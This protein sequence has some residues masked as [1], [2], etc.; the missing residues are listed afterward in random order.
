MKR[1]LILVEGQTEETFVREVL[2]PCVR[3]RGLFL[4]V[5]I[6]TTKRNPA[7]RDCKGGY[8]P[9]GRM[10]REI[11]LLLSDSNA[12]AVTTMIDYYSLPEDF[13]GRAELQG[14]TCYERVDHL[15]RMFSQD[16]DSPRFIPYISLHEFEALLFSSPAEI[17]AV[18]PG[19]NLEESLR[20]IRDSFGSPE[21]INEGRDTHPSARLRA[22]IPGYSKPFHGTL[23]SGRIGLPAIRS[24]C[25]HFDEWVRRLEECG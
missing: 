17:A 15:E 11:G 3:E 21:E 7:G 13:P 8:V 5:S 19:M 6:I 16:V 23:I 1:V 12:V 14:R 18:F 9:Y 22:H 24:V 2:N 10:K 4:Q 20:G 25:R